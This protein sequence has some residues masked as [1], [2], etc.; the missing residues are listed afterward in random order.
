MG[1]CRCRSSAS[2][3]SCTSAANSNV[4]AA[5]VTEDMKMCRYTNS[6][7]ISSDSCCAYAIKEALVGI[8][9][10]LEEIVTI[11]E[12]MVTANAAA[13]QQETTSAED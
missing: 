13:K 5:S 9:A 11:L 7:P 6:I 3:V 2:A 12:E 8:E 4:S 1:R 10:A